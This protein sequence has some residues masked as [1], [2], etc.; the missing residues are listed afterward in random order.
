ML[1]F[2]QLPPE[3]NSALMYAGPGSGPLLAAAAAWEALAAE[4]H[5]ASATYGALIASLTDG[6]WEGPSASAMLAAAVPQVVWLRETAGQAEEAGA[7]A[8]AAA[9]AFEAAFAGT[10]PPP[11]VAANRALLLELLATNFLGQNTAAIAAVETEYAEMWAQDA[12]AM[13]GYAGASATAA[14]LPQ[15]QSAAPATDPAGTAGQAAAVAQAAGSTAGTNARGLTTVPQTLSALAGTGTNTSQSPGLS[16]GGIGMNDEGDGFALSGPL[17]D[18]FEGLTGS[19]ELDASSPFDMFIRLVSPTRLFTTA[20]KDVQ[21]IAQ[22]F[23]PQAAKAA[24][25]GAAKAAEGAAKA[26]EAVPHALNGALGNAVGAAG[27]AASVGGLSVPASWGAV[28]P[29]AGPAIVTLN[30]TTAA[31]TQPATHAV[32]GMPLLGSGAARSVG[33]AHFAPPRYGFKP[34]IITHPP[35]GG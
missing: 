10:V 29:T 11:V 24:T 27:R 23:A 30:G 35:A 28:T 20:F 17:G 32:G 26:I 16:F 2:A 22:G 18:F 15:P 31:A 3:I 1:D 33:A 9:A 14:K 6:P 34:T 7:Q 8:A 4:L 19:Q 13:Y 12:G 5:A 21:S 25:E